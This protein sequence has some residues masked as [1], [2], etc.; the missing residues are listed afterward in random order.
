MA[1]I[2]TN[3][4]SGLDVNGLV[5]RLVAAERAPYDNRIGSAES[6]LTTEFSAMAQLK[7]AMSTLQSALGSLTNASDFQLRKV[8]LGSQDYFAASATA[9][10]A[11]GSYQVEV[12]Q[13]ASAAQLGSAAIAGGASALSGSGTIT[14]SLGSS[15]FSVTLTDT[16]TLADLRDAINDADANPGVSAG[17]VTDITGTHLVLGGLQ[18]GASNGIRVS[19][20]GGNGDLARFAYDPPTTTAMSQLTPAQDSIVTVSGYEIHDPDLNIEGAIEGVSLSLKQAEVGKMTTL[21][22]SVDSAGIR[23]KVGRFVTAYNTL[24]NQAAKLRSYNPETKAAGPLLGDAML[25]GIESQLSRLI[26]DPVAGLGSTPYTTLA[27]LGITRD[28]AG[29]LKLDNTKFDAAIAKDP[30]AASR[31]FTADGGL[32]TRMGDYVKAR[33]ASTGEFAARDATITAKRKDID[34]RK[35]ALETR[36][37]SYQARYLKQFNALDSLLTKMQSTSSYLTQQLSNLSSSG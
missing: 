11:A 9:D 30:A 26:S 32:G 3:G 25:R 7:G 19:T 27:S 12:R 21:G 16:S 28:A 15:S 5:T 33:L 22:I 24:A 31:L 1:T 10:A 17:L 4:A 35:Q 13:L 23:E 36:M 20:T 37:E 34:A 14:I 29:A 8:T 2:T 18:T 6:K